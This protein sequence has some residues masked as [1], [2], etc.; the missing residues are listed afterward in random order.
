MANVVVVGAQWGDEGKGKITD[1]LAERADVVV[2][3]AGGN[4]AG[5]TVIVGDRLLK[6]HLV[7]SGILYPGTLCVI[8]NGC[9]VDP[10]ALLQELGDLAAQCL[11]TSG[12]RLSLLAHVIMPWHKILDGA[13]ERR[14]AQKIGTTGKGI[15]PAYADKVARVGFRVMDLLHPT[16]FR[17]LL[18]ERLALINEVLAKVHDL[19]PLDPDEVAREYLAYGE[20]LAP[21]ATDVT[22]L[23]HE[24]MAKDDVILF[25]GA[26]GTL[27]DIDLGTYP[28]VTSSNA[29][30]G[31]ACT[32][33]GVGPTAIDRVLGIA[34]AYATRVGGGPFPTELTDATGEKLREIGQEYGTTTG[35]PRRCG[36][37][38]AVAARFAARVNGLDALAIT[39]LDVLDQFAEIRVCTAY[40]V[41]GEVLAE[42]PLEGSVLA[43]AEAQYQTMPGWQ[44]PTG[45]A[46][47]WD[48]LPA[49]ARRYL[50]FLAD[51]VGVPISIVSVGSRRDQT[52][53]H[54]DPLEG[55]RRVAPAM[56]AAP[57]A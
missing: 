32:G 18:A 35:R 40:R 22:L 56:R 26:Q 15:G 47:A 48:E 45:D 1:L 49:A 29:V 23:L 10:P 57:R 3:Y 4:N 9:V 38:D 34:K 14:R 21:Y 6:L 2:R 44:A 30:A 31:G 27:L 41:D 55:P 50:D 36:W 5:H 24:V 8:G 52:V 46:R 20:R 53:V 39:K 7:P 17:G 12:L 13:E 16:W 25:E 33:A 28:F 51:I 19:P 42:Y 37:F 54:E 43:R 11:D